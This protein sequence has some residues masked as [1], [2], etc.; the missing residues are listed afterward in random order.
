MKTIYVVTGGA[1]T[2][3]EGEDS[4]IVRAFTI[5]EEAEAFTAWLNGHVAHHNALREASE[6]TYEEWCKKGIRGHGSPE[7]YSKARPKSY[8]GTVPPNPQ[9]PQ[10]AK[11]YGETYGYAYETVELED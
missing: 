8:C 11:S 5:E 10:L 1:F 4:W 6:K 7:E 9:D 2:P 3:Y